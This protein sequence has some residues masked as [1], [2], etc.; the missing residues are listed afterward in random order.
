MPLS[1][2]S[3]A[4]TTALDGRLAVAIEL[5][6]LAGRSTLE[7]FQSA[8]IEVE[9]KGDESP[10]T[11][12]DKNAEKLIRAELNQ[13]FPADAILG[14]EFGSQEGESE[15]QWIVDPI[16]GTKSFIS[17]VP[18]YSTLVGIVQ[19]RE[20]LGG[21]IYLPALDE[22]VFAARGCGAWHSVSGRTP[23]RCHVSQKPLD[24]GLFV[25]SQVDSFHKRGAERG[26]ESLEQAAYI[27]RSWGDGYGYLL[28]ATGR[29]ELMVDPIANPW[30]LAA[31]QPV[32]EEAGGRFTSW[33]GKPTVFGG[34]GLGSNGLVHEQALELLA[35]T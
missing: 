3:D 6:Q 14:E 25:V 8:A 4:L 35:R 33:D 31:V 10:V 34:D 19:N 2:L 27:T 26:Y 11:L 24:Q 22:L 23:T 29:A 20:C 1:Q 32:L 12:A 21:V 15:F 7:L 28:V 16:D 9:R 17:G 5:A 18:L 13:R 30:D